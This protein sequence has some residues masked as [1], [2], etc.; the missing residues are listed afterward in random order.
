[1]SKVF[2]TLDKFAEPELELASILFKPS[3]SDTWMCINSEVLDI[4]NDFSLSNHKLEFSLF[5]KKGIF[6]L[7]EYFQAIN[8]SHFDNSLKENFKFFST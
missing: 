8:K 5:V 6:E 4:E 7:I 2:N 1:M 3:G